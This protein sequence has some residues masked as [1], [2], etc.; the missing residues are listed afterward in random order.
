MIDDP[1][2]P[3]GLS[4]TWDNFSHTVYQL[5][6]NVF[7]SVYS[8][9]Q[10]FYK[11][12][13]IFRGFVQDQV[14]RFWRSKGALDPDRRFPDNRCRKQ[15]PGKQIRAS[16]LGTTR[17]VAYANKLMSECGVL[18]SDHVT[19]GTQTIYQSTTLG[20]GATR[21]KYRRLVSM[22]GTSPVFTEKWLPNNFSHKSVDRQHSPKQ[23]RAPYNPVTLFFH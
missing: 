15:R 18:N 6:L 16:R 17:K 8:A 14:H 7:T 3:G 10:V 12:A 22:K 5:L 20:L 23:R 11:W 1:L 19:G 21:K 13:A 9:S 4:P 2:N